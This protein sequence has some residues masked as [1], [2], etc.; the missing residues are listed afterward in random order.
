MPAHVDRVI[1]PR[2]PAVEVAAA[3][4]ADSAAEQIGAVA[5][6]GSGGVAFPGHPG[7]VLGGGEDRRDGNPQVAPAP[8]PGRGGRSVAADPARQR[9]LRPRLAAGRPV[10]DAVQVLDRPCQRDP[11]A[12]EQP[13][14]RRVRRHRPEHPGLIGQ[15][16]D[17]ADA[18][19]AIRDRDRQIAQHPSRIVRGLRRGQRPRQSAGQRR[20]VGQI[21]QQPGARVRHDPAPSAVTVTR[22]RRVVTCTKEVPPRSTILVL[23]QAQNPLQGGHF[24]SSTRPSSRPDLEEPGL[25]GMITTPGG[26]TFMQNDGRSG[27]VITRTVQFSRRPSRTGSGQEPTRHRPA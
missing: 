4:R 14:H 3:R 23:Q 13:P 1:A 25:G 2:G 5:V 22:A 8:R 20:R 26:P 27:Q 6:R 18:L 7:G 19:R 16:R 21:G 9:A 12:H 11:V 10:P 17:V 15:H 24:P